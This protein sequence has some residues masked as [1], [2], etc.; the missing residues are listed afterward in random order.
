MPIAATIPPPFITAEWFYLFLVPLVLGPAEGA[1]LAW[2]LKRPRKRLVASMMLGNAVVAIMARSV[3][4]PP[5]RLWLRPDMPW[6]EPLWGWPLLALPAGGLFL[7]AMLVEWP[8]ATL[9]IRTQRP[10]PVKLLGACALTQLGA[11]PLVL[12]LLA[13]GSDASMMLRTRYD[14]SLR[15]DAANT[16]AVYYLSPDAVERWSPEATQRVLDLPDPGVPA[17]LLV[18][19]SGATNELVL[20]QSDRAPRVILSGSLARQGLAPTGCFKGLQTVPGAPDWRL[21]VSGSAADGLVIT[22]AGGPQRLAMSLPF[23]R[24]YPDTITLLPDG[25]LVFEMAGSIWLLEPQSGRILAL[26]RGRSPVAVWF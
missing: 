16:F 17:R 3:L 7:L 6:I 22:T 12:V 1:A 8:F 10:A 21:T 2:L 4:L 5:A 26:A 19:A 14:P 15:A 18:C 13:S 23:A 9:G 11:F 24:W 25:Q 20:H